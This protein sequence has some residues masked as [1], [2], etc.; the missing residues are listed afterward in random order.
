[1][2]APTIE[3][4]PATA[5]EI[6]AVTKLW[7]R[8]ARDQ[9]QYD[10]Y[11]RADE[12][13]ETMRETLAAHAASGGLLVARDDGALVGFVSFSIERGTIELDATRGTL[14]NLYVEPA[15]REHGVG[16][17]LL[18]RAEATLAEQDVD[19]MILEVMSDNETA[20]RFYRDRGYET[21]R[22]TMERSLE[23]RSQNDTHSKEET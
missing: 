22:V 21:F 20:R 23:D 16:T 4:E 5:D 15:Y 14:S 9:R 17:A 19:V 2:A 18:E 10:S 8:L 6:D 11:V 1:M 13:R 7:V 12:N 3:I